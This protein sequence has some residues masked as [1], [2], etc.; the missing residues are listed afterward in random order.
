MVEGRASQYSKQIGASEQDVPRF[1]TIPLN[2]ELHLFDETNRPVQIAL[3]LKSALAQAEIPLWVI[4]YGTAHR[5]V[6]V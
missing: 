6:I 5:D 3:L 1:D 4:G 2:V